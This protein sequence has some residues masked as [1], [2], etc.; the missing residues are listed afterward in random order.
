MY[1][2]VVMDEGSGEVRVRRTMMWR[3]TKM[4][5]CGGEV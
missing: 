5:R 4:C 1:R 3:C 2:D